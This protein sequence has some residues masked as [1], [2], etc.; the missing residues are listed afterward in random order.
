MSTCNAT[1]SWWQPNNQ[2]VGNNWIQQKFD[3]SPF[4]MVFGSMEDEHI[5]FNL[6]FVKSKL[7]NWL[8]THLDLMV[9]MYVQDFYT[10]EGFP[11]YM[12]LH[13]WNEQ[14]QWYELKV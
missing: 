7:W 6:S 4:S 3:A 1:S 12:V 10:M 2:N 11:F 9:N 8:T 13:D 14:L 5:F